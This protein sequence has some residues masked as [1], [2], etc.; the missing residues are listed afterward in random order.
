MV[1]FE[2]NLTAWKSQKSERGFQ[3]EGEL[4][5]GPS[6]THARHGSREQRA[7][8]RAKSACGAVAAKR[9]KGQTDIFDNFLEVG[10]GGMIGSDC[11]K[12]VDMAGLLHDCRK[13][14]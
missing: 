7:L 6:F 11:S 2:T 13:E 12:S 10:E 3:R 14:S 5:V 4:I 8:E 9:F 1:H